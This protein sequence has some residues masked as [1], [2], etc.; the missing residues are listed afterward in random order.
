MILEADSEWLLDGTA[1]R[2]AAADDARH[3]RGTRQNENWDE[4]IGM[5]YEI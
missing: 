3:P 2:N 4:K 5:E 1:R